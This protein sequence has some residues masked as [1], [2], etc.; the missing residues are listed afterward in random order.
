MY[1]LV[2]ALPLVCWEEEGLGLGVMSSSRVGGGGGGHPVPGI[3][4]I[5][6]GG[7]GLWLWLVLDI[8]HSQ[9]LGN[10]FFAHCLRGFCWSRDDNVDFISWMGGVVVVTSTPPSLSPS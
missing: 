3:A 6:R 1:T 2:D 7:L 8:A 9:L 5:R 10:V 4:V